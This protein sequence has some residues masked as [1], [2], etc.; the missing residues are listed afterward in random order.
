MNESVSQPAQT[1]S[2]LYNYQSIHIPL[3]LLFLT[4]TAT[5]PLKTLKIGPV[6]RKP[7]QIKSIVK[8]HVLLAMLIPHGVLMLLSEVLLIHSW[9]KVYLKVYL[10]WVSKKS[11]PNHKHLLQENYCTWNIYIYIYIYIYILNM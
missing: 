3:F 4:I 1:Q 11:F 2:K 9:E 7:R 5:D 6:L 8:P 10:Y